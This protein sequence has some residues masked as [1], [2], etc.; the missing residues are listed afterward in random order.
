[1]DGL[2]TARS[3]SKNEL[4]HT[5]SESL[6][7]EM[8]VPRKALAQQSHTT[9]PNVSQLEVQSIAEGLPEGFPNQTKAS[10][11]QKWRLQKPLF[12]STLVT[13]LLSIAS[14]SLWGVLARK[15]LI[16]LTSYSGTYLGGLVWANFVACYVMGMAIESEIFWTHLLEE[17]DPPALFEAKGGIP[18]YV[19]ITTGFCGS[20]SSFSSLV[21]EAFNI[22]ANL[23]PSFVH[24]PNLA[25]GVLGVI[26]V[27]LTHLGLSLTGYR[28]GKHV[29]RFLELS[30]YSLSINTYYALEL[31]SAIFGAA[32]Y[33]AVIVLLAVKSESGWRSLMLSCLFAPWGSMAR[34]ALSRFLNPMRRN[35][36]IG[37]Y[38]ANLGGTVLLAV[39]N[40]LIRGKKDFRSFLPI[41]DDVRVC[42]VLVGLDDGFCGCLTTVST[43]IV[44]LCT[45]NMAPSYIYGTISLTT[46]FICTLLILGPYN[47]TV[48]LTI[49]VC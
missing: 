21:L 34:Y 22:A 47:W 48:G 15:G 8:H 28:T 12:S 20:C 16:A 43:F 27:V 44:E 1:M 41:I 42:D 18:F 4:K 2:L 7:A 5:S 11:S 17:E 33:V 3:N 14:G 37:T 32:G 19:G 9:E 25:Y 40:L 10:K 24:Y 46:S 26:E 35:F 23:P 6:V 39:L 30:Q 36:P 29:T 45:L 49:P 31:L 13:T 38:A